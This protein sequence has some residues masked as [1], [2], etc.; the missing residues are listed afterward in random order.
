MKA[1]TGAVIAILM[2]GLVFGLG[3]RS[4]PD[5]SAGRAAASAVPAAASG[6]PAQAVPITYSQVPVVAQEAQA[7]EAAGGQA[8]VLVSCGAGQQTLVRQIWLNGQPTSQVEC[9]GGTPARGM[10]YPS[11][12]VRTVSSDEVVY[13][14]VVVP[15]RRVV[16]VAQAPVYRQTTTRVA[17]QPRRSWQKTALVIGGSTAAGAG[18]GG[19]IGG[20]KGALIGAAIGGGSSTIYE[21]I[22]RR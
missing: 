2:M 14:R 5:A 11:A 3:L 4:L 12:Q 18:V 15:E 20:K 13:D 8:P 7:P 1:W 9:I 21:A 10:V 16:Q 6:A 19:I 22:K 17:T